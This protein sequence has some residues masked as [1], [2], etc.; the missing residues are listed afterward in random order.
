MLDSITYRCAL[1]HEQNFNQAHPINVRIL[2]S[3]DPINQRT[4]YIATEIYMT[5]FQQYNDSFKSNKWIHQ[6]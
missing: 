1:V 5:C 6:F 4:I 3:S 2:C